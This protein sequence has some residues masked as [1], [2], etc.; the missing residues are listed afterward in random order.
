MKKISQE[1]E[2]GTEERFRVEIQ[3][4]IRFCITM[5]KLDC[6]QMKCNK[7]IRGYHYHNPSCSNK[8]SD[9]WADAIRLPSQKGL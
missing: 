6:I 3:W 4:K 2:T 9:L 7:L 1:A 5:L 8:S